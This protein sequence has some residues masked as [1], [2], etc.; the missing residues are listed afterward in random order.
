MQSVMNFRWHIALA[1]GAAGGGGGW[2]LAL[3]VSFAQ[4][5]FGGLL[6]KRDLLPDRQDDF[7]V[8]SPYASGETS[9]S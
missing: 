7:A 1:G 8:R 9:Q 5:I 4:R 6:D 2:A 3:Q